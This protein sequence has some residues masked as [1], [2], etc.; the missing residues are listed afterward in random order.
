MFLIS[1][2]THTPQAI[3]SRASMAPKL[4]QP[5]HARHQP[6][7]VIR[8]PRVT[9]VDEQRCVYLVTIPHPRAW[10]PPGRSRL[11]QKTPL[12][13]GVGAPLV[14]PSDIDRAGIERAFLHAS[15]HLV[16][17]NT[18]AGP[19]ASA[20][21]LEQMAIFMELHKPMPGSAADAPRLPHYHIALQAQ[22][23][24]RYLPFK[25]ALRV[26]HNLATH[27]SCDHSMYFSAVRYG[28]LPSPEKPIAELDPEPRLWARG[29]HHKPLMEACEEP[30]TAAAIQKRRENKIKLALE[31]GK[32]EPRATEMDL[33]AAIVNGGYRNTPDDR[34]A[35]K[36]LVAH[37]KETNPA[38]YTY[39][40]KIRHKLKG[41]I[42]DVWTWETVED[43]I[44]VGSMS[45]LARLQEAAAQPCM[46]GGAWKQQAEAVFWNNHMDPSELCAHIH[47]SLANGCGPN[48]K[49]LVLAGQ[50]GGE[51]K[52]FLLAPLRNIFGEELQDTPEAGNFPLMGLEDK[53]V[54]FL[55][56][57]VFSEDVLR[58]GTQL[59][60]LEGKPFPVV[61][62]Q[63]Q[64]G[65]VG[66]I[67]YKG[68]APIFITTKAS[69]LLRIQTA[70]ESARLQGQPSAHTMLLRRLKVYLLWAP[71]PVPDGHTIPDCGVC[72]SRM[73][74]HFSQRGGDPP[75]SSGGGSSSSAANWF[76]RSGGGS[77]SSGASWTTSPGWGW[78]SSE[79]NWVAS[80]GWGSSSSG[81]NWISSSRWGSGST[82]ANWI[83]Y[84]D[85]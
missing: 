30:V 20:V 32:D 48:M 54:V 14:S 83:D 57:W 24:F 71:T 37:L 76:S 53:C 10:T 33:Y 41:L 7:G 29:G 6:A 23:T 13:G 21:V 67:L 56:E 64:E 65:V 4:A 27:W 62:P 58:L 51:G 22:R 73:V 82:G 61:Q 78:S 40:F 68:T 60:W 50:Y 85:I 79:A 12:A 2:H 3:P 9:K 70:A 47:R 66:H 75:S 18:Y 11:R 1:A 77:S 49:V 46:C 17:D 8:D 55:D 74:L 28:A 80:P 43:S 5:Q 15:E 36:R 72:F 39:A 19:R 44:R 84:N 38:L 34:L 45:R 25:R 69:D 52:S 59:L 81:S 16:Y 35:W 31:D 26:H 63:N 42:N